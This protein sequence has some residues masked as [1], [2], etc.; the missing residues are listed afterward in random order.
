[1]NHKEWAVMHLN[2][3]LERIMNDEIEVVTFGS[4]IFREVKHDLDE[5]GR[6]RKV[7]GSTTQEIRIVYK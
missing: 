6:D 1:M 5:N 4:N 2:S 7:P 3:L